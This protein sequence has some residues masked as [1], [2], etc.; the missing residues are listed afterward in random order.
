MRKS[1]SFPIAPPLKLRRRKS[2]QDTK[3]SH[4]FS[5]TN[6]RVERQSS[7]PRLTSMQS[8]EQT[9][10]DCVHVEFIKAVVPGQNKLASPR[11]IMRITNT[12]LDQTWEMARTFKEFYELKES[13]VSL[14]DYGHFCPS[15]CPWLYMYAAHHFPRRRIFRS[16]SPSVISRRISDLQTYFST[17]LRMAKQNRNLECSISSTKLPQLIYDFLFEGMVFDRS[18]FQR[19]SERPSMGGRD[20]S[21]LD[22]DPT[23]EAEGCSICQQP[24]V[25]DS[26][27]S[28]V[29][30]GP[31]GSNRGRASSN[32]KNG[33][34]RVMAGLTTL[35][36][37]HCFH[38]E[39]I[40]VTDAQGRRRFHGAFTGG[41]S[42]GYFNSVGTKEGW[43]PKTFSSSRENRSSRFE[44]RAEDFMDEDDDP[45]LGKRLETTERYDTLQTGAKRRLQQAA[46]TGAA[47]GA[48]IPGFALPDDWVLPV[49]DS[50]GATLLKQMGWKEGHGIG[51]R[52]RKRKFQEEITEDK[53]T[54]QNTS[55]KKTEEGGH[56]DAEEEVYVP[57]RKMFDVQK[58]FPKPKLDR[59][60]AG[61]DPYMN[62]PE[63]SRY[64]QQQEDKQRE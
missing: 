4:S 25:G 62:A 41:F 40:L 57:P 3:Q 55:E 50:I 34:K 59:Y 20:S 24:L 19:L 44:Q 35:D 1:I 45:L 61:F 5:F 47:G 42:A 2:L 58:A 38:D 51:Q 49:N 11:Y 31:Y 63:F 30:A 14:L 21:F 36:C 52:V 7:R 43:T 13:I 15:N 53:N 26:A 37:G 6:R 23:Q 28:I 8:M 9:L 60:G 17:L 27:V 29:P 54:V 32:N 48:T 39:C 12:M 46:S 56:S 22:N 18:D 10:L 16:R 33:E 64:K